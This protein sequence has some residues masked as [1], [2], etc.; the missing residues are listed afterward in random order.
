[1]KI[2]ALMLILCIHLPVVPML[3]FPNMDVGAQSLPQIELGVAKEAPCAKWLRVVAVVGA[4]IYSGW[5]FS[6]LARAPIC[7]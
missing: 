6:R 4:C 2:T 7:R 5:W 1:M 3:V